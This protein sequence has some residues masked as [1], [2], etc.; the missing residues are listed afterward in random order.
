MAR[1]LFLERR[2][3]RH[4]R[5]QDAARLLPVLGAVLLFGPVFIRSEAEQTAAAGLDA[6]LVY[7]FAIW[8]GLIGATYWINRSL[9]RD[10]P[11]EADA[12]PAPHGAPDP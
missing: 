8:A 7:F 9:M 4:N 6:W 5:L 1:R 11:G 10:M 2:T 3:Y 12:A